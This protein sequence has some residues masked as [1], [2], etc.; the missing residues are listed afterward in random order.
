MKPDN[1][2]EEICCPRFDPQ[3]WNLQTI[4]WKDKRLIKDSATTFFFMPINFGAAMKRLDD[5][6]RAAGAT[7]LDNMT[8]SE[9]TSRWKMYLYSAV[10]REIPGAENIL[11]TGKFFCKVYEG[12]FRDTGKWVKDFMQETSSRQLKFDR[13]FEWYTTCPK[14]AKK[15]GKNYVV[16]MGLVG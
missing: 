13:M 3:P 14:C 1:T 6:I 12:E 4:E 2:T 15:Y 8:L 10:D 16:M 7:C 9:H 5:K 11:L